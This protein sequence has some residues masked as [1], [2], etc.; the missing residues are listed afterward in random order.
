MF[1]SNAGSWAGDDKVRKHNGSQAREASNFPTHS[2]PEDL[3]GVL[4][5]GGHRGRVQ[6][7]AEDLHPVEELVL[8]QHADAKPEDTVRKVLESRTSASSCLREW[9]RGTTNS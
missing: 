5:T 4:C 3:H 9:Q 6:L 8:L 1:V 2:L 7:L